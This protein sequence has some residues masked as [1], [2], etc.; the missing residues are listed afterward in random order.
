MVILDEVQ[1][2]PARLLLPCTEA[3]HQLVQHYRTT[4][5]LSTATQLD[6]PGIDK[7][8]VREIIPSTLN[9]YQRLKR[10]D[11]EFPKDLS[12][13]YSWDELAVELSSF[14]QV[15]CIVNTRRDCHELFSRM[16]EGTIHLSA[17]MCGE[18]RSKVIKIIKNRLKAKQPIRVISTQIVEAGVDIDF[19]V[20]YRAFTGLASIAQAGGRC[21][22]E[23]KLAKGSVIVF[24]P[25]KPSP[26][27]E[28]LQEENAMR[29]LLG[30]QQKV[31]VDN[32]DSFPEYFH[33]L[34]LR[35]QDLGGSFRPW[36]GIPIPNE[37]NAGNINKADVFKYQFR[38]AAVVFKMV[39]D[40]YTIP[41]IVRY[42]DNADLIENLMTLGPK[43]DIMRR[44][45]RYSV[46]VPQ[47]D[48]N[49]L[50]EKGFVEEIIIKSNANIKSGIFVQT[51]TSVYNDEF[52][53]DLFR[54]GFTPKETIL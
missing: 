15:L 12:R 14:K 21:N 45:Q 53:L 31:D 33:L 20:V 18:H 40:G 16:P 41:V 29:E 3:I 4:V 26:R 9:L 37:Y 23:G 46:N 51:L 10:T 22:R 11:V 5:L 49:L 35:V 30:R 17:L 50:L 1:L 6:L 24:M 32:Q 38:E 27:G 39:D 8:T 36:L 25:H 43:R 19:P 28:L 34:H 7:T 47:N 52:G 42:G 13:R 48:L 2:L 54:D 44:L